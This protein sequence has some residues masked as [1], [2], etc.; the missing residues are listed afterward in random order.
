M[1][2]AKEG[3]PLLAVLAGLAGAA[4]IARAPW[5]AGA[6]GALG[7]FAAYFFRDP[8]RVSPT[9]PGLVLSPAD[10]RVVAVGTAPEGNPLGPGA[11]QV[12]IFLSVFDVHVNRSPVGG[13]VRRVDYRP[14]EFLPAFDDKA[15]LR[16]E[17][18]SV[19]IDDGGGGVAF[20]Q[21]AGLVARRIVF[22]KKA[23]DPVAAG[24]RVGMIRF[25]SR[26]DLFL[27]SAARLRVGK[28]DRVKAG[29]SVLAERP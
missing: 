12:S 15:S 19:L 7:L 23:G 21:I 10:G 4:L 9:G 3:W 18:N 24:E 13:R 20:T 26:V 25:G 8:E 5:L 1:P 27:P 11:R 16:N 6:L 2:V 14:G 22:K 28:G 29:L 17:R